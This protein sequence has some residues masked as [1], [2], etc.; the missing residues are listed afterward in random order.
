MSRGAVAANKGKK[1]NARKLVALEA[2]FQK[3]EE[4]MAVDALLCFCD[5][6]GLEQ[7][8]PGPP[9]VICGSETGWFSRYL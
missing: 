4:D 1:K 8:T 5:T 2:W 6:C 7:V 9:C 3:I